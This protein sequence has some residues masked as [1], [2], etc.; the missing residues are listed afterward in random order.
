[1]R[2]APLTWS[3]ALLAATLHAQD[4]TFDPT[5]NPTDEGQA[6]FD[7]LHWP[8]YPG[9]FPGEGVRTMTVQADGKLLVGG[10]FSG[11]VQGIEDPVLRP[12]IARL[13][14]D[15][16]Q[17]LGFNAGT[18]FDG[19]VHVMVVQPD[20]KILVGGAFLTCH[21]Q[22]RKGIARLNA[23][24]SLDATFTVGTGAGGTVMEIA[25]Q[26]DGRIL[27]GGNFTS[28]NGVSAGRL[29][30]LLSDGSYDA[31]L[32]TLVG[33][34]D[35]VLAIGVQ[36]DGQILI[37]GRFS[38]YGGLPRNN[39]ARISSTGVIDLS[40]A[41][42]AEGAVTDIAIGSGGSAYVAGK[43]NYSFGFLLYK[44]TGSG[45]L[46]P[47]FIHHPDAHLITYD[48]A[49][50]TVTPRANSNPGLSKVNGTTGVEL[51]HAE[52]LTRTTC[53]YIPQDWTLSAV[54]PTGE[55]YNVDPAHLG[56][57]RYTATCMFDDSFRP[58]MGLG[59][60]SPNMSMTMD[61][62]G[63]VL[64][65]GRVDFHT[66]LPAHNGTYA[67][68]LYRLTSDGEVDAS[69]LFDHGIEGTV[70]RVYALS[71]NRFLFQGRITLF[72]GTGGAYVMTNALV[73]DANTDS[74]GAF[75]LPLTS[76]PEQPYGPDIMDV[77]ELSSGKLLYVGQDLCAPPG[78]PIWD[79][80]RFYTNGSTDGTYSGI[81]LG[82]TNE[83]PRCVLESADGKVYVG[84]G[85]TTAAGL[86]RNRI[87]RLMPNGGVDP[88]FDPLG[89]FDGTVR[90]ILENPDGTIVCIG[91]FTAY[92]GAPAPHI[93]KLR[94][95]ASMDPSFDPGSGVAN[96][97]LCMLRYPDG[98]VL[99]GGAIPE[100]N[101]TPVNGIVCI[102]ADGSMDETFAQGAGFRIN[103]P[104]INGGFPGGGTVVNMAMQPN[105]Q[106]VCMGEFHSYDG[107]G[108]NRLVR[109]GTGE[110][111]RLSAR[112]LLEGAFDGAGSM[113]AALGLAHVPLQ[114]PYR[115][116][117][118]AHVR[119]GSE[120]IS[121]SVLLQ[122][123]GGAIVDWV[124]LELRDAQNPAFIVGTRSALLRADGW[125]VDTDGL[126]T[127][128]FFGTPMG[129]YHVAVR[130]RNHL[131]VMTAT[132]VLL[133]SAPI[134]IDFTGPNVSTY[135][136]IAQKEVSGLRMLWAGDVNHDGALKYTGQSNDRDPILVTVGGTT[137]NNVT[138]G[139]KLEDINL[140]GV[141]KYTGQDNDRDPILVNAGSTTPN[142]VRQAQLP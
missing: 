70:D 58:G 85:F 49:T 17:D 141:V 109:I 56:I 99:V 43:F 7:G 38:S 42:P 26:F 16:S 60:I 28:F 139:Y 74:F 46:D 129:M 6:R 112:V 35:D 50:N 106:V 1:M 132:P 15:G 22:P 78:F 8:A 135:G 102:N 20:G 140:D 95:D 40:Y 114:E 110:S 94:P 115:A 88:S 136:N 53:N 18:G 27:L 134:P 107:H 125:I 25:L 113:N 41:P 121:P 2:I 63:R 111:V 47:A 71:G 124:L 45:A 131:G 101:G 13:N 104:T 36:A 57:L 4:A 80:G 117:G 3:L 75:H 67:P 59:W 76:C 5:F 34:D 120:S 86:V 82:P 10:W 127:V 122:Q 128:Q 12:G 54:G 19:P 81:D 51:C 48:Q 31:S 77:I 96:A 69:F 79:V 14:T 68:D 119:G 137:P 33:S 24:G 123:G 100:Y 73:Y 138:T 142:N 39:I 98:R 105:G 87:V 11:G 91:D 66:T 118:F 64:V 23:D 93:A 130:H 103:N 89:G 92:R 83:L 65:G 133:G 90:E 21:G 29:V 55:C 126:S 62:F 108:R 32:N 52:M 9:A 61:G 30:R 116:L 37:G 72:C 44:F 97:P 84:G